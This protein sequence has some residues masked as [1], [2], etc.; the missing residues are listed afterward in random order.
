MTKAFLFFYLEIAYLH[1]RKL[2]TDA[3][4]LIEVWQ[5]MLIILCGNNEICVFL[6]L[7]KMMW[8]TTTWNWKR[9]NSWRMQLPQDLQVQRPSPTSHSV[10]SLL[11]SDCI[12]LWC[13]ATSCSPW[14]MML[15]VLYFTYGF[16]SIL[17]LMVFKTILIA[18]IW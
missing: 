16:F 17:L 6:G 4:W 13:V 12:I 10:F 18:N 15:E 3:V 7:E 1:R 5:I 11:F 2:C 9:G 14:L 8:N